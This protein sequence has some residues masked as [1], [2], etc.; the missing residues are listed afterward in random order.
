MQFAR[1]ILAALK[2]R[3]L[4]GIAT[5]AIMVSGPV[6][7]QE[8]APLS[9][10]ADTVRLAQGNVLEARGNVE[11]F[12]GDIHLKAKA[13]VYDGTN[14]TL[15]IT[16][17][18]TLTQGTHSVFLAS[19]AEMDTGL[20]N[21]IIR[22]ARLV[23]DQQLQLA[24]REMQRV[25]GRYTQLYKTVAS[26]CR[27]CANQAP[28]WEIRAER[29]IHDQQEHQLYFN[30]AQL[31][32]ANIP[33]FYLP[34]LRLPD[35]TVKR[36]TGFLVPRLK[37]SSRLGA[38]I[39][40][41]YFIALGD[42]ADI[43][44][45]PYI[46]SVTTTAEFRYR[47]AFLHGDIQFDGA[48][49]QDKLTAG[50]TRAYIF[51]RGGFDLPRDY[52]LS[53]DLK[54]VSDPAYLLE[55]GYSGEDRLTNTVEITRTRAD[56]YISARA[57]SFRTLRG[58]ELPIADQLPS[59]QASAVYEKRF[60]PKSIGGQGLWRIVLEDHQRRSNADRIGRDVFHLGSEL[61]WSRST[62]FGPGIL[63]RFG[64]Q[65]TADFYQIG[66][67]ST[68][69]STLAF[70][71][72]ALEAELRWPWQKVTANGAF[73]AFEPVLHLAWTRSLGT[74]VPNED[75]TIVEFDEGNLFSLTHFPGED[76]RDT[77]LR[78]TAGLKWSRFD[79]GNWSVSF[80][81]G[82]VMRKS[83]PGQFSQA[84]GLSGLSSDWLAAAQLRLA[85]KMT[86]TT[87]ALFAD[88]F[89]LTKAESRMAWNSE[90]LSIGTTYSWIIPDLAENRPNLTAQLGLDASYRF[91]PNWTASLQ[92]RY[93]FD[94]NRATKAAIGLN[95]TNECIRVDFSL[96]RR[97][98]SSTSVAPTTDYG[99]SFSLLGFGD[100]GRGPTRSCTG[101]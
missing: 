80:A 54:M 14:G 22:S 7:A 57:L 2:P 75:S 3:R 70:I 95:Y 13:I 34:R 93:D 100:N 72:P 61:R 81:L 29:I 32:I 74:N 50:A 68:Y 71:T 52:R 9:L 42:H 67:D 97:F 37:N 78:A 101:L 76:R 60:F 59:F 98:T 99:L 65:I 12:A 69:P 43:T 28:L 25:Q 26:S 20:K 31:R 8:A 10:L 79:P 18:I 63:G 47:Q 85:G 64:G 94:A 40:I 96:S 39:K 92:Y 88:D 1:R 84:S 51:G 45:T 82:R 36:A 6:I 5:I 30:K 4:M 90:K 16:G 89:S 55:Y 17:P 23:L 86:L 35:P 48:V 73:L 58:S 27:V 91:R 66:Q 83:D 41:P 53:F 11:V 19:S 33:V 49:T 56:E 38:G 77:G 46:S 15:S 24:A 44:I 87:R 21:G 62:V